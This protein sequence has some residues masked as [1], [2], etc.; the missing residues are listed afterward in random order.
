MKATLC[1]YVCVSTVQI[2][3]QIDTNTSSLGTKSIAILKTYYYTSLGVNR[4]SVLFT[5]PLLI[6]LLA[7]HFTFPN[8]NA[9]NQ[10]TT[11]YKILV[12]A[13]SETCQRLID[14]HINNT[15]P[16]LPVIAKYDTSNQNISGKFIIKNGVEIRTNPQFKNHWLWYD[17][18]IVCVLCQVPLDK[19]DLFTVIFLNPD[20]F[21]YISKSDD[22]K[23]NSYQSYKNRYVTPDCITATIG[24]KDNFEALFNDT[25]HYMLSGC[26]ITHYITNQTNT[27]KITPF[28][29]NNPFSTLLMQSYLKTIM[30]GTYDNTNH[31]SGGKGPSNCITSKCDFKD[32]YS[33]PGWNKK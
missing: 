22:V 30:H 28:Q 8:I 20:G 12:V 5:I 11:H 27:L 2:K 18:W 24:S 13:Y 31:T 10:P 4:K 21:N 9:T 14:N 7:I 15:C 16:A 6:V 19:P 33:K 32:P 25:I 26:T 29:H 17:N 23:N 3:K 1:V